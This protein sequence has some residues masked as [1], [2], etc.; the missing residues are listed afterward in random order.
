M[1]KIIPI[2]LILLSPIS[3]FGLT[4]TE[5]IYSNLDSNGNI[6]NTNVSVGLTKLD[7]GDVID[8]TKLEDIKN[9]NGE[10][11]FTKDSE[12]LT[13]KSTGK[14]IYYKGKLNDELP[15]K[16]STKYYLNG[17]EKELKDIINKSGKV[18]MTFNFKNTLYDYNSHMYTPFV[19]STV[20][21]LDSKNNSNVDIS[22][23]K[24]V[25]TGNKIIITGVSAPGL[26]EST[27]I[28]EL[29]DMDHITISFDTDKFKMTD[30]YF[31]MSPKLLDEVDLDFSKI[32]NIKGSLNTLQNG[33]NSLQ[34]GSKQIVD[35]EDSFNTGLTTLNE[36]LKEASTGSNKLYE[37]LN[38]VNSN[39]SK[40]S[41]LNTLVDSLYSNYVKNIELLNN[42]NNGTTKEQLEAGILDAT[43]KKSELETKLSEV[44]SG[45]STLESLESL[46][47][48]QATQ[49]N[50]LRYTKTQLEGG[51]KEYA[52]G[53]SEAQNNLQSLPLYGAKISGANEVI[54][55]V[56]CGL[57]GIEDPSMINEETITLFK[58]NMTTLV[59]GINT[60][61]IGSNNLSTG[62]NQL[63]E[64]SNKLVEGSNKISSG[65][66]TLLEGITKL[67]S[68]GISKLTDYGNKINNYSNKVETLIN[69]SNN[70]K[71]FTS[72]NSDRT[73]FIYKLEK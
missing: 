16:I 73:I 7:K 64:G 36:G 48:E 34:D 51:I 67:N 3:V 15:I 2:L 44:N 19:V 23:G 38:Q 27:N 39:T 54:V 63:Y 13:W 35:G 46:T 55:K 50:T 61:T 52:S 43:N 49:L 59:E 9:V 69:L 32:S 41:N 37:G 8:Y 14:D 11:K 5:T 26:Y 25:N 4:K 71:G 20:L 70:Y 10:E 60:L 21:T 31:V 53:I 72:T 65:N 30:V 18:T 12:K 17:E 56:L 33:V 42:I 1:K 6:K 24:V 22:T 66:K 68:E 45:I 58:T 40:L 28:D 57:L 62:L 47:E 29:K